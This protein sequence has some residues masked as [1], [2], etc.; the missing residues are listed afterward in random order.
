MTRRLQQA[1]RA[2]AGVYERDRNRLNAE[3][4]DLTYDFPELEQAM[5]LQARRDL[6]QAER[7]ALSDAARRGLIPEDVFVFQ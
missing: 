6:L 7:T 1:Y 4:L 3:L 5:I 2:M